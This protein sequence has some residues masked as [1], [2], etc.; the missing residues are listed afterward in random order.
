MIYNEKF[1][2]LS[3]EPPQGIE[4]CPAS[5]GLKNNKYIAIWI[6][7]QHSQRY[8]HCLG[9]LETNCILFKYTEHTDGLYS[10]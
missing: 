5:I 1:Y 4:I 8:I 7:F 10:Y 2:E 3:A 6:R 9:E